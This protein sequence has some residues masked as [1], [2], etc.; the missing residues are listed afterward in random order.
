MTEHFRVTLLAGGVGGAKLAE[1]FAGL[2]QVALTVIGNIADDDEFHGLWVSPDIDT[3]LYTLGGR[4]NRVQGWGV[5][6]ESEQALTVLRELGAN[7][8]MFLGDRDLGLHIYRTERLRRGDRPTDIV[9]DIA[10][11]F[12]ITAHILL[13]TDDRVQ[14]RVRSKAGW[15]AFQEYFVRERYEP[16]VLAINYQGIET[17]KPTLEAITAISLADLLVIAPSNPVASILPILK[18]NGITE[19]LQATAAPVVAVSPL[20]AG[21]TVKGPAAEMM[22]ALGIRPDVVGVSSI[23]TDI[24]RYLLIDSQD[25]CHTELI[26]AAGIEPI[27]CDIFMPDREGKTR[28]ANAILD[29]LPSPATYNVR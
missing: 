5:A 20:I 19:A 26:R 21:K 15:L 8:W 27:C 1:G 12:G 28:L 18:V 11:S 9:R 16:R 29:L 3:M 2:E 13:P 14:T 4:I 6:G 22:K 23:Y 7:T 25:A 10:A 17:A 24:A